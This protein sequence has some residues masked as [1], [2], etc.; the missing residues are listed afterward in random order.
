MKTGL[1][2]LSLSIVHFFMIGTS[3]K[4]EPFYL[5]SKVLPI[6]ILLYGLWKLTKFSDLFFRLGGFAIGFSFL[7]D[8][9]LALPDPKYFVPGLGSFL[10]AQ[11][12]YGIAFGLKREVHW[13]KSLPFFLFGVAFL[14]IL[15][16]VLGSLKI[17][18][19]IYTLAI[20]F[21]GW[22]S[23]V[24]YG[25]GGL[26][27]WGALVFISSDSLIA[28]SMFLNPELDRKIASFAIMGTYYLAQFLLFLG[29]ETE[30]SE[31]QLKKT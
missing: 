12:C 15:Y 31:T 14:S 3:S 19:A 1:L 5:V 26:F 4:E 29:F 20:C 9:F 21:M 22:K 28:Y 18:V 10:I 7:G 11:V 13:A 24:I 27:L 8:F 16:P 30:F 25:K 23:W 6:L 17:P 2:Y